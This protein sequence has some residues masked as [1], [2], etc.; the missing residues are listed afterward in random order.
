VSFSGGP[1]IS[2]VLGLVLSLALQPRLF[3]APLAKAT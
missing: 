1:R 2:A 3:I